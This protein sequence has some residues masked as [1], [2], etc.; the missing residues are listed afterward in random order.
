MKP[1]LRKD[2]SEYD[3]EQDNYVFSATMVIGSI[4]LAGALFISGCLHLLPVGK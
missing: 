3:Q 4:I 1:L 2:I